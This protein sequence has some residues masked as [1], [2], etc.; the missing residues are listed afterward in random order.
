MG[1][2]YLYRSVFT[3]LS[4]SHNNE[5]K[6]NHEFLRKAKPKGK[7]TGSV[8]E[9]VHETIEYNSDDESDEGDN[10]NDA[11]DTSEGKKINN[12]IPLLSI[13]TNTH[14]D[15]ENEKD[16]HHNKHSIIN[17]PA[18]KKQKKQK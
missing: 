5:L 4:C 13:Q 7:K 12:M 3:L 9:E 17:S 14:D 10:N 1:L 6:L 2:L 16:T 8:I 18:K 11:C 15:D